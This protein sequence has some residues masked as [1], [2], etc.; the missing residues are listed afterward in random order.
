MFAGLRLLGAAAVLGAL[1]ALFLPLQL[2]AVD[3]GGFRIGCGTGWGADA[4]VAQ[5]MD[6]LNAQQR[7]LAGPAFVASDY[8]GECAALVADR[9][10]AALAVAAAGLVVL[11][12][13]VVEPVAAAANRVGRREG[14]PD[15]VNAGVIRSS[16]A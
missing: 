2:G 3:R 5:R 13:T 12:S 14:R 1:L 6:A 8:A 9:R 10:V 4:S 11:L 16:P 7:A 15:W